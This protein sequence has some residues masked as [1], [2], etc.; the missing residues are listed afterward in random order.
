[1]NN[2][3]TLN[4][5]RLSKIKLFLALSRTQHGLLDMATPAVAALLA[6]G[7][8]PSPRVIL[9]GILTAFAG[10]TAVYAVND[11]VDYRVDRD[12]IRKCGISQ[13]PGDLDAV[14]VRHPI[15]Q[16]LLSL[17]EGIAWALGWG[18]VAVLGAYSLNPVCAWIFLAGCAAETV[19]CLL[20][21]V[22][23]LR[24]L[25]SGWVK[26]AGGLAAVYA[27]V[28][29]P[30]PTFLGTLFLWLFFWEIGGQNVPNDWADRKEDA[31]LEAKTIPVRF[32]P[33]DSARIVLGTLA[34]A[35]CLSLLLYWATP[36]RM[37]LLYLPG[38]LALGGFCLLLPAYKL[39]RSLDPVLASALF[40]TSSYYPLGM[41][42][43]VW[44]S[45]LL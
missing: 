2:P 27:V 5:T 25:V 24:T 34:A 45:I 36:T 17:P 13:G 43:L 11:V 32:G 41:L 12:K 23:Y 39:H 30:S 22:S 10:Y 26:T 18:V 28:P 19:Y 6:L 14:C 20:L 4:V 1:M 16:G 8:I 29:D 9:L 15:A 3:A 31:D 35:V 33:E 38:T 40:N 21:K 7:A 44:L 37:S 42:L